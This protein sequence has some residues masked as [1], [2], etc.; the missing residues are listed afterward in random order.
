MIYVR[1]VGAIAN[2][3]YREINRTD[4]L[5][6]SKS[7]RKL[8]TANLLADRGSGSGRYYVAGPELISRLAASSL[9]IDEN[10]LTIDAN[11]LGS[12]EQIK[13]GDLPESLKVRVKLIALG[14]R[15]ASE[16]MTT[17]ILALCAWKPLSASQIAGLL[18][19]NPTYLTTKYLSGLVESGKL[20]YL[21]SDHPNH[22]NQKYIIKE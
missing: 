3:T 5:A 18:D 17:T 2:Q 20:D 9:A 16:H 6:A 12:R 15:D 7:L 21:Y 1:E 4:T 19:R 22:P 10:S 13:V 14:R 11:S 8:R